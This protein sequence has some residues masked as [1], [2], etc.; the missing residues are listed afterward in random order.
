MTEQH[1]NDGPAAGPVTEKAPAAS[2]DASTAI[3]LRADQEEFDA[4]QISAL[5]LISPGLA[6]AP[7]AQLAVFFHYCVRTGLDPFARQIYMIGRKNW[8]AADD[9]DEPAYIW[10]I[11]TGIDGFRATAHKAAKRAGESL[12][13]EDTVYYDAEGKAYD[14]WLARVP[15]AAVKVTVLRG[16]ARFPFIARWDEFAPTYYD[17]KKGE[18]VLAAM[19]RQ[20]PSHMLRKC[21]EAGGLRMAA[22]HDLA[23]MYVDEEMEQAD[24]DAV[25]RVGEIASQRLREAAARDQG[26]GADQEGEK[27]GEAKPAP[28]KRARSAAKKKTDPAPEA[29][30]APAKPKRAPRKRAASARTSA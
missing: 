13:Y 26:G 16:E 6:N 8:K 11:Q 4:R 12:S 25:L 10:T 28:K 9:P 3:V 14:V 18:Y 27:T 21:A 17:K 30:E 20:M 7:R 22:P 1:P 15:P 19:W 29:A 5:A 23:G 24:A 2:P